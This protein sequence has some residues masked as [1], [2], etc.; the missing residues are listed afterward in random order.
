MND[1]RKEWL[2]RS[3]DEALSKKLGTVAWIL[4]AVVLVLVLNTKSLVSRLLLLANRSPNS[5]KLLSPHRPNVFAH[6]P[7]AAWGRS[8]AWAC[9]AAF[10]RRRL[11]NTMIPTSGAASA[12]ARQAK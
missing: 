5:T 1:E 12:E 10:E 9:C 7:P 6:Q 3:P 4:T 11:R 2:S 8:A